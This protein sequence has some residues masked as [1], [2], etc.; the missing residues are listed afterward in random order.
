[1]PNLLV[2]PVKTDDRAKH[3]LSTYEHENELQGYYADGA[4][5]A[6]P[7]KILLDGYPVYDSEEE[8]DPQEAYYDSLIKRF[9]SHR[10]ILQ[11]SPPL[12][13]SEARNAAAEIASSLEGAPF[14]IRRHTLLYKAP[15]MRVLAQLQQ[16]TV[17]QALQM[18]ES[19]LTARNL[20]E[21]S[22][23]VQLGAWC[24]GLLG[25]CREMG[26]MVSEEVAVL[27]NLGKKALALWRT[28]RQGL[29]G[30]FEETEENY[31]DEEDGDEDEARQDEHTHFLGE[32]ATKS[33]IKQDLGPSHSKPKLLRDAASEDGEILSSSKEPDDKE[34]TL[35]S[36]QIAGTSLDDIERTSTARLNSRIDPIEKAKG[37]LIARLQ[38]QS[39]RSPN[40]PSNDEGEH[41]IQGE[42]RQPLHRSPDVEWDAIEA[43][44]TLDMIVTIIGESYGQRDLLDRREVWGEDQ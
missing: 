1:M 13:N 42:T 21:K 32:E 14:K 19:I 4:Y 28:M 43:F 12:A 18:V 25:K 15:S 36:T 24:W 10:C 38:A 31:L 3:N 34:L 11:S 44:A 23:R 22:K 7:D 35:V 27:R 17:L 20:L 16:E 37:K 39:P 26:E 40:T 2:A 30:N 9:L 6:V 33:I 8:T 41:Q 29:E 5:T